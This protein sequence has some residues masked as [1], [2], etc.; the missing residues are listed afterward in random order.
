MAITIKFAS[1]NIENYGSKKDKKSKDLPKLIAKTMELYKI[2]ILAI[3]EMQKNGYLTINAKIVAELN[4]LSYKTN[5]KEKFVNVGDEGVSFFWHEATPGSAN[6]FKAKTYSN[7]PTEYISGKVLGDDRGNRIY[8]PKTQTPW[9]SLPGKPDGR[10]PAF[11][12]FETNTG[13]GTASTF[14]FFDIHTPFNTST[15]IQAYSAYL[16]ST[17]R[18]IGQVQ[19]FDSV[20]AAIH[21]KTLGET[22]VENVIAIEFSS[23]STAQKQ[24]VAK[25]AIDAI[26][27]DKFIDKWGDEIVAGIDFQNIAKEAAKEAATSAAQ[28][29]K[30]QGFDS[31]TSAT[32]GVSGEKAVIDAGAAAGAAAA[33]YIFAEASKTANSATE[34]ANAATQAVS[35]VSYTPPTKKAKTSGLSSA[36]KKAAAEFAKDGVNTITFSS[37]G[38]TDVS[39]VKASLLAGDFNIDYPDP[40]DYTKVGGASKYIKGRDK[41]YNELLALPSSVAINEMTTQ[42]AG[43]K[44]NDFSGARIY[45]LNNPNPLDPIPPST[46]PNGVPQ[47]V[48]DVVDALKGK[49]FL[50]YEKWFEALKAEA[51]KQGVPW[52]HMLTYDTQINNAFDSTKDLNQTEYFR[53]SAYDNIFVKNPGSPIAPGSGKSIDILSELGSWPADTSP[54]NYWPKAEGNLNKTASNFIT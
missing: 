32:S 23:A 31:L 22:E 15:L 49:E 17:S 24:A 53:V 11:C 37:I 7:N 25:E 43:N 33:T 9:S 36:A 38:G 29:A 13:T 52:P 12:A 51:K 26:T 54:G 19:T 20:Q 34:A 41:A 50:S 4:S 48:Y 30:V 27:S 1:W 35:K 45:I 5:W 6:A 14:T 28:E 46:T 39:T 40:N 47:D 42:R 2:D 21:A 16:Y 3:L 8:F 10:R 18:E 44:Y